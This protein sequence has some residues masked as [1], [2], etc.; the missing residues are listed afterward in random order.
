LDLSFKKADYVICKNTLHHLK[1]SK[2]IRKALDQ[3]KKLGK[4]I[5]IMDVQ[6]PSDNLLA[7]IWNIYY[8]FLLGDQGENFLT[9]ME[10]SSHLKHVYSD[11]RVKLRK[12]NTIKGPYMMAVID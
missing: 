4:R 11:R 12:V 6:N 7:K 9:Y 10:F 8:R 5:I 1:T 2:Q 3:L